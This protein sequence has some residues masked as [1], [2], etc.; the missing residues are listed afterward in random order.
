MAISYSII[1]L[2]TVMVIVLSTYSTCGT[3]GRDKHVLKKMVPGTG[4]NF[5]T[6]LSFIFTYQLFL[7][8]TLIGNNYIITQ[9]VA[10]IFN[11][12]NVKRVKV[13]CL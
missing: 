10:S 4:T 13:I 1:L 3:L 9:T 5:F 8:K 11:N 12:N 6:N 7:V 2:S